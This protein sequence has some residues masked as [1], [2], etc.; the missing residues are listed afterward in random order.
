MRKIGLIGGMSW[1]STRTYYEDIN[2]LVQARTSTLSS[3]PLLIESLDF[4]GLARLATPDQW[5]RAAAILSESARRLEQAGAT[6]LLIGANSMHKVYDDVAGAVSIPVIHIA[7]TVAAKMKADGIETAALLGTRYVVMESFYR[8]RLVA[9]GIS[10]LPPVVEE[11]EA[12]DAIIYDELMQGKA[13]R[14]AERTF[15]TMLTNMEQRG[16]QA[17]VL[18]CTELDMVIDVDANVL[19]IY[20]CTRIHAHA[21]VDWILGA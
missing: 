16:A 12:T 17:A 19:P 14:A 9:H 15:K 4:N 3:A 6:A 2:Q 21:A 18:A 7:D 5:A 11:V 13:T 20:D 8:K 10:L 1:F